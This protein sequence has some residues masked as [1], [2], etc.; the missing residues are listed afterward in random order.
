MAHID[1]VRWDK[2]KGT[3]FV[4]R[5]G[6]FTCAG[7]EAYTYYSAHRENGVIL[8][9][10]TGRGDLAKC[11]MEIPVSQLRAVIELLNKAADD[12]QV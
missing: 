10:F 12:L 2:H 5:N 7:V 4:G 6:T 3:T 1:V 8:T 9:P 11:N